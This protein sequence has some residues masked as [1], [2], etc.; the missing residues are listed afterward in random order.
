MKDVRL[1]FVV[2]NTCRFILWV[3]YRML[4]SVGLDRWIPR[5]SEPWIITA[6]TCDG[7]VV[8]HC[9]ANLKPFVLGEVRSE[10]ITAVWNG[11]AYARLRENILKGRLPHYRCVG[12]AS[13]SKHYLTKFLETVDYNQPKLRRL[14]FEPTALCNLACASCQNKNVIARRRVYELYLEVL[15]SIFKDLAGNGLESIYPYGDGE[16]FMTSRSTEMLRMTRRY[17]PDAFILIHTNGLLLKEPSRRTT[18]VDTVDHIFFSIDGATQA[19]YERYRRGG[20]FETAVENMAALIRERD[21]RGLRSPRID[22]KY[23]LFRWNS[24]D[25]ELNEARRIAK[26]IGVDRLWF[27][28]TVRPFWGI[29]W[30]YF[31]SRKRI[32]I[33]QE[34]IGRIFTDRPFADVKERRFNKEAQQ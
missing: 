11:P 30:K 33:E 16:M 32:E 18:V 29:S 20:D 5:C 15:E 24:S 4:T 21:E 17:F 1:Q 25:A 7:D 3:W 9:T 31:L 10:K 12:C 23:L 26:K 28:P 27:V 22:W 8:C 6:V 2:S 13:L 19:G 14:F 34:K